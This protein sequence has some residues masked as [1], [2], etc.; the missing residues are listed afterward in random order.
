MKVGNQIKIKSLCFVFSFCLK[1]ASCF[2]ALNVEGGFEAG[3][4]DAVFNK[5]GA[6]DAIVVQNTF[7]TTEVSLRPG[8]IQPALLTHRPP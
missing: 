7:T 6:N 8:L 4:N 5:T 3:L 2:V 1:G